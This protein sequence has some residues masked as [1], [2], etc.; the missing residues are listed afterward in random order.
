MKTIFSD[1]DGTFIPEDDKSLVALNDIKYYLKSDKNL[2]IIYV[3]G[4]S[5]KETKSVIDY[6]N[7]PSPDYLICDV[8]TTIYKKS[9]WGYSFSKDYYSKQ[10]SI[11]GENS[12]EELITKLLEIP[13]IE[14][15]EKEKQRPFKISFY[16]NY[17]RLKEY[18][19]DSV[20]KGY[21]WDKIISVDKNGTGLLDYL[22]KGINKF[23]AIDF[24]INNN[25]LVKKD[26][27]FAG[28]SG[29][30]L[31]VFNSDINSIV[32]NNCTQ[33]VKDAVSSRK[34]IYI[35]KEKYTTGVFE[36]CKYF[37]IIKS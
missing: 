19:F 33:S 3:T 8:G 10:L 37:E 1:L 4:R 20:I 13:G 22:P 11:I 27:V 28:D 15:Q 34:N 24:F 5:L 21:N 25:G 36:G 23:S 18:D 17:K 9:L 29:N 30:D 16:F 32:V 14:L 35:S 12:R 6:A 31:Q 2:Q 7:L 26:C